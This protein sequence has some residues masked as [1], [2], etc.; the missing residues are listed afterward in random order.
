MERSQNYLTLNQLIW[1]EIDFKI[2]RY[3]FI[4]TDKDIFVFLYDLLTQFLLTRAPLG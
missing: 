4:D 1:P 2:P 3:T